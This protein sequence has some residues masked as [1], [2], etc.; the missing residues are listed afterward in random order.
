MIQ[1]QDWDCGCCEH[2]HPCSQDPCPGCACTCGVCGGPVEVC[3]CEGDVLRAS[4]KEGSCR[5][6]PASRSRRRPTPKTIGM[7]VYR[8]VVGSS[9]PVPQPKG[10]GMTL[11]NDYPPPPWGIPQGPVEAPHHTFGADSQ[12]ARVYHLLAEAARRRYRWP[13]AQTELKGGPGWVPAP[14]ISQPW[15]GGQRGGRCCRELRRQGLPVEGPEQAQFELKAGVKSRLSFWRLDT[16][17]APRQATIGTT[18]APVPAALDV[19]EPAT[20]GPLVGVELVLG[21]AGTPLETLSALA[22]PAGSHDAYKN[23]L[24]TAYRAGELQRQLTGKLCLAI[25]PETVRVLGIDPTTT[26]VRILPQLGAR[27]TLEDP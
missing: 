21:K 25:T 5:S 12:D 19:P 2:C 13:I 8:V 15:A 10:A 11:T 17:T 22:A 7:S 4:L 16:T 20:T 27:I 3:E 1:L 26:L 24:R 14:V 6:G 9:E 23:A 18:S